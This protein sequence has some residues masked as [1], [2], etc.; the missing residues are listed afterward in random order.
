M[1]DNTK[2]EDDIN[3]KPK[4]QNFRHKTEY[5]R[6][7]G[8]NGG[9][10]HRETLEW[11]LSQDV[12]DYFDDECLDIGV[13]DLTA[14]LKDS[15]TGQAFLEDDKQKNLVINFDRQISISQYYPDMNMI[16]LN[17]NHPKMVLVG[18]LGRGVGPR[19]E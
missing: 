14:V 4:L 9:L 11:H 2:N 5:M 8:G 16:T 15:R 19:W 10:R 6:Q 13:E 12:C 7:G 17:P 1:V 18:N 3:R